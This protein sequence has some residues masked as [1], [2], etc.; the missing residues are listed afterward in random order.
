MKVEI[1]VNEDKLLEVNLLGCVRVGNN[2][3]SHEFGTE[4][5]RDSYYIEGFKWDKDDFS[6]EDNLVIQ[7][8]ID[9]NF[10]ELQRAYIKNTR[11]IFN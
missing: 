4:T 7:N 11:F 1:E 6:E 8:Y 3:F 10:D 2:S 5:C 9:Q